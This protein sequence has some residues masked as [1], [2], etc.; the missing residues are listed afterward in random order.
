[1]GQFISAMHAYRNASQSAGAIHQDQAALHAYIDIT[2]AA[3]MQR[4]R[5]DMQQERADMQRERADMQR[6]RDFLQAQLAAERDARESAEARLIN[7]TIARC[8]WFHGACRQQQHATLTNR[9]LC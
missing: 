4:E 6:E 2:V 9:P 5:A 1:M 8:V 3:A 7:K